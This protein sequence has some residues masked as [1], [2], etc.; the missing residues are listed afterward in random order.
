MKIKSP[1]NLSPKSRICEP[2]I[3]GGTHCIM[4]ECTCMH[5][6]KRTFQSQRFG[7]SNLRNFAAKEE[8]EVIKHEFITSITSSESR[9][10]DSAVC[11][12]DSVLHI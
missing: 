8:M 10:S 12:T 9:E 5:Q 3:N 2:I 11:N 7:V 4:A 1:K 6:P